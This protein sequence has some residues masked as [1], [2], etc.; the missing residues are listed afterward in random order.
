MSH[1]RFN[2][3]RLWHQNWFDTSE[4]Q[5]NISRVIKAFQYL[6]LK[7][8]SLTSNIFLIKWFTFQ[9]RIHVISF[10]LLQCCNCQQVS[11]AQNGMLFNIARD[12]LPVCETCYISFDVSC[13]WCNI[14]VISITTLWFIGIVLVASQDLPGFNKKRWTKPAIV[15]PI[16][17]AIQ[18]I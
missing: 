5:F 14:Y 8:R 13:W 10:C 2:V 12:L 4:G 6:H 15:A 3:F 7:H 1:R 17:G 9:P 18:Y 11:L 16:Y